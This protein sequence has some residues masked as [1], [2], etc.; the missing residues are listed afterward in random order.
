MLAA[1]SGRRYGRPKALVDTGS[2]PWVQR[3]LAALDGFDPRLV[4][5]GA[6]GEE[7]ATLLPP[8]VRVVD[9]P[10]Y[11]EG[12]GSSL[13]VGLR[14]LLSPPADSPAVDAVLVMLVDLP[15]VAGGVVRRVVSAATSQAEAGSQGRERAVR[16][17]L[18]RAG[19][20]GAPGHPV[21][22]GRDH[23]SGVIQ[24]AVGDRGARDYLATHRTLLVECGDIGSGDDVDVPAR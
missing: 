4:V 6:S 16:A 3:A 18:A 12:I 10:D 2:G 19:F 9:N 15:R 5:V 20:H 22:M 7:V 17:V 24:T 14:A 11:P 8:G 1:G 23:W 21:L 13:R